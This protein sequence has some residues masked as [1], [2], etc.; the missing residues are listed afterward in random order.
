M[1]ILCLDIFK[2]YK[3]I[4]KRKNFYDQRIDSDIKW[5]EEIRKITTGQDEDYSTGGFLDYEHFEN[6]YRLYKLIRADEEN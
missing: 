3:V 2:I 6:H 5:Y 4:V 1:S